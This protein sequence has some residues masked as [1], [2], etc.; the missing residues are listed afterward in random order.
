MI[1]K[2]RKS[3]LQEMQKFQQKMKALKIFKK[4]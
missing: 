2:L 1:L 4:L 3:R